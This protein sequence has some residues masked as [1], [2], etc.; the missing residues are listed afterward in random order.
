[1]VQSATR[2]APL[3]GGDA[4]RQLKASAEEGIVFFFSFSGSRSVARD[5]YGGGGGGCARAWSWRGAKA[6]ARGGVR[7]RGLG[8]GSHDQMHEVAGT[9]P[10]SRQPCR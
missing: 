6:I 5:K 8:V 1:V 4:G 7:A 2:I 9:Q 3:E 10:S